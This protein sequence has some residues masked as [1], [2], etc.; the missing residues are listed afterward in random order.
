MSSPITRNPPCGLVVIG[1]ADHRSFLI[2]RSSTPE[3]EIAKIWGHAGVLYV[4]LF[5]VCCPNPSPGVFRVLHI[6]WHD[7]FRFQLDRFQN[8]SPHGYVPAN[9]HFSVCLAMSFPQFIH[10]IPSAPTYYASWHTNLSVASC[11]QIH[12]CH[13]VTKVHEVS[14]IL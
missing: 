9:F 2:R 10:N 14:V 12:K 11:L 6:N 8:F 7:L 1:L 13:F 3:A 5:R 4:A